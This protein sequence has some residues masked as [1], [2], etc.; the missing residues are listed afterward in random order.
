MAAFTGKLISKGE[1]LF[2]IDSSVYESRRRQAEAEVRRLEAVLHRIEQEIINLDERVTNAEQMVAIDENDYQTSQ[3]LY[4][5]ENVGTKR[6][7]DQI[8]QKF[9]RQKEPATAS[10]ICK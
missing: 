3:E 1:L 10:N 9:L 6:D 5:M 8:Y 7:V 4:E 2:E